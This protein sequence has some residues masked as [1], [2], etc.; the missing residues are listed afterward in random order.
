[1]AKL[2]CDSDT[3]TG[4]RGPQDLILQVHGDRCPD[5]RPKYQIFSSLHPSAMPLR[6]PLLFSVDPLQ[7]SSLRVP[8]IWAADLQQTES[9]STMVK[10]KESSGS[11]QV[12]H[13]LHCTQRLFP[14]SVIDG[15]FQAD[16]DRL[17]YLQC[18]QE[19]LRLTTAQG[20]T[21]AVL[22]LIELDVR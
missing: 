18:H 3:N 19:R 1:M 5:G 15:D 12:S 14:E 17:N 7:H 22:T 20:V 8:P 2:I 11:T 13:F 21:D 10:E 9:R 6:Y 16:T 4:D